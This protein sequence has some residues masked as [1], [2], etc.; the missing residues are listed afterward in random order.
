MNAV[1]RQLE[2]DEP[3]AERPRRL[4]PLRPAWPV[5]QLWPGFLTG[6]FALLVTELG[7]TTGTLILFRG[8]GAL[9]LVC[10]ADDANAAFHW[11]VDFKGTLN[12]SL[13]GARYELG[14]EKLDIENR[15]RPQIFNRLGIAFRIRCASILS[16]EWLVR[17]FRGVRLGP[18]SL[19]FDGGWTD[20]YIR[21]FGRQ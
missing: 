6:A 18:R 20:H 5:V 3:A 15:N 16:D 10:F 13:L 19:R 17:S 7:A 12:R 2:F 21:R 8:A 14:R 9:S 4:L 1:T 11:S